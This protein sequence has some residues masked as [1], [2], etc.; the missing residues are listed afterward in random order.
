MRM[1]RDMAGLG[2]LRGWPRI[3]RERRISA[4]IMLTAPNEQTW[5]E[6]IVGHNILQDS[7]ANTSKRDAT[8][9]KLRMNTLD[10]L[11]WS[12]LSEGSQ[13]ERQQLLFVALLPQ[14]PVGKVFVVQVAKD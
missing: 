6:Q 8:T 12:L 2:D 13:R 3:S 10:K 9:I 14:S 1:K 7:S 4:E 11:A 5:Q